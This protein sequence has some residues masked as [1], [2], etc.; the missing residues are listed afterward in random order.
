MDYRTILEL[1]FMSSTG[2]CLYQWLSCV[3][4]SMEQE[5]KPN[6]IIGWTDIDELYHQLFTTHVLNCKDCDPQDKPCVIGDTI[7]TNWRNARDD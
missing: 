6:D 1:V 7:L 2:Y 4:Q 5:D 3:I